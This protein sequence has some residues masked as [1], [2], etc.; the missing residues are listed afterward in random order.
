RALQEDG[1]L[2]QVA[3]PSKLLRPAGDRVKTDRNDA[4]L[5][6]RLDRAGDIVAVRIP[7]RSEEAARDLVRGRD[8]VR[9]ELMAQRHRLSKLLLRHGYAFTGKTAWS[10][11]HDLWLRRIRRD[12]LPGHGAGTVAAFD[13]VYDAVQHTVARRD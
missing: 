13:D 5:L 6:A 9:R 12:D 10:R 8:D 1:H 11:E 3:A 7:T 2:V 4:L